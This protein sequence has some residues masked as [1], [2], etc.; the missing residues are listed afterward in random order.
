MT[1][2]ASVSGRRPRL[3]AFIY[4]FDM[5]ENRQNIQGIK[6]EVYTCLKTSLLVI[7]PPLPPISIK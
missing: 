7:F 5:N 1:R 3:L 2:F 6:M 4:M